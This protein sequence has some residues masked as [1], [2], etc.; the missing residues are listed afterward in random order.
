MSG[1]IYS[2]KMHRR[3]RET[4]AFRENDSEDRIKKNGSAHRHTLPVRL[5]LG[6]CSSIWPHIDPCCPGLRT[7]RTSRERN[8]GTSVSAG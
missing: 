7:W 3:P 4:H 1:A 5:S 2:I 8:H 6:G